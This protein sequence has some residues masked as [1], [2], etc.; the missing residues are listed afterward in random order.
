[1]ESMEMDIAKEV[2]CNS[3]NRGMNVS[4]ECEI[5]FNMHCADCNTVVGDYEWDELWYKFCPECGQRLEYT[6]ENK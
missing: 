6:E 4:G 2:I 1:M 5:E 3:V